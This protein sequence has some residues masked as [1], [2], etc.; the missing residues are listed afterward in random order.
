[1]A[2]VYIVTRIYK[3]I[4]RGGETD[5]SETSIVKIFDSEEKAI[6]YI[7]NEVEKEYEWVDEND[8]RGDKLVK[9]FVPDTIL[10]GKDIAVYESYGMFGL[11]Y[12]CTGVYY[13]YTSKDVE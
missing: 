10:E 7:R 12:G 8:P 6:K 1:M 11:C 4:D 5:Y 9:Y 3:D 13:N 2:K